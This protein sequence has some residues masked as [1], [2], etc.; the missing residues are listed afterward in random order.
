[1]RY[2]A[3]YDISVLL[4]VED[5]DSPGTPPYSRELICSLN[6]DKTSNRKQLAWNSVAGLQPIDNNRHRPFIPA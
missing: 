5:I 6:A 1:M 4:G 2:E 3:V